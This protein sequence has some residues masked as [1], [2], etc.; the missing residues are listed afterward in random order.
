M[1]NGSEMEQM[2]IEYRNSGVL[3]GGFAQKL[4]RQKEIFLK[5][6]NTPMK[7]NKRKIPEEEAN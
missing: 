2:P 6:H 5:Q 7:P 3:L 1:K 4:D